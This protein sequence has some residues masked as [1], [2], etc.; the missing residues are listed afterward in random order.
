MNKATSLTR[1][2][3]RQ[4]LSQ[5]GSAYGDTCRRTQS[6]S[7]AVNRDMQR[8]RSQ[9]GAVNRDMR[10]TRSQADAVNRD[11]R[12]TQSQTDAVNRDTWRTLMRAVVV[13][14]RSIPER[15]NTVKIE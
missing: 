7:D 11:T 14:M 2:G 1:I 15:R 12:R 9:A 8:T 5:A 13:K 10:R 6:H 4:A 3:V